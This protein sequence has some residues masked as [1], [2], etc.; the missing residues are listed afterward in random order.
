MSN[1]SQGLLNLFKRNP[2]KR[3]WAMKS[4]YD[5]KGFVTI[6]EL[7]N[8]SLRKV[9]LGLG[10]PTVFGFNLKFKNN[11]TLTK[12][13]AFSGFNLRDYMFVGNRKHGHV[14]LVGI[15][16]KSTGTWMIDVTDKV[17]SALNEIGAC[18]LSPTHCKF[19][20]ISPRVKQCEFCRDK[21]KAR[22]V[23]QKRVEWIRG[24]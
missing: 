4:S 6:K 17:V 13:R 14:C 1:P 8:M 12:A 24:I 19:K 21:L 9:Q 10:V 20:L 5:T 7:R 15:G 22:T 23:V 18:A 16:H 11:G 2:Y 3:I